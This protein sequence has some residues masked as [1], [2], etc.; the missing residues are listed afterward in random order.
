MGMKR[1][2]SRQK[3]LHRNIYHFLITKDQWF[4]FAMFVL[5]FSV[6]SDA[7]KS[8]FGNT[9]MVLIILSAVLAVLAVQTYLDRAFEIIPYGPK[10]QFIGLYSIEGNQKIELNVDNGL[11]P[12]DAE[13]GCL[14]GLIDRCFGDKGG[15]KRGICLIGRSGS[16]KSTIINQFEYSEDVPYKI[17]NF[18]ESYDYFEE[19]MMHLFKN[20]PEHN[21]TASSRTVMILDHFERYFSLAE[22]KKAEVKATIQ[23]IAR[24]PAVFIFSMRE[25]F[26]VSFL[27]EFDINNLAGINP[28]NTGCEGILFFKEYL[29]GSRLKTEENILICGSERGNDD[30]SVT[31]TMERLCKQAFG[32]KRGQEIYYHF[33]DGTLIQQQIIFNMMKHDFDTDGEVQVLDSNLDEDM[34]MKRY[35]DVQL[36]STGDYYMASRIMYLLCMG[37][38]SRIAFTDDDIRNA[39]CIF[40]KR[41]VEDF[42]KCLGKLHGLKL[43]KYSN[44]NS[45]MHY[46][47]AHD[48]IAKSFDAYANTELP[49]NVK[50][51][52]DEFKSEYTRHTAMNA[53]I[54]DYRKN[55][56]WKN[57][58]IFGR[59]V[60]GVSII[61]TAAVWGYDVKTGGGRLPWTVFALC[62]ASLLY[63][64]NFFM[65][66]TRHY[67]KGAWILVDFLYVLAM[68]FG[69]AA[70]VF[71]EYWLH[72][73]GAGNAS[74]GLSCLLIG[75]NSHLAESGRKWFMTY[76]LKTF[77]VGGLL[78]A[79]AFLV[80]FGS[81]ATVWIIETKSVLQFLPMAALL[82]YA[83]L[84]HLNKEFFYAGVEGI[85]STGK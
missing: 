16:G 80:Q 13:I 82:I 52:L 67:R 62:E 36:C 76:G 58:G 23:R 44:R 24:L 78:A 55:K 20:D 47:I 85:F 84:S 11:I 46:E 35:Y 29:S 27:T 19:Y 1:K 49:G 61:I 43:I 4:E 28:E 74:M 63:V 69:T 9:L 59:L 73:L 77:A 60:F 66:I 57:T 8:H 22:A 65:N 72:F 75:M 6:F 70:A 41:D 48:Y 17:E 39:L 42:K 25:E 5:G 54:S 21:L 79:L 45:T 71:S 38:N 18:S 33:K 64:F 26:F 34:M 83:Y 15:N 37:R 32:E 50:A 10:Q 53:A 3:G 68:C 40:E 2:I 7:L 56:K 51:A 30:K 12:R 14:K 81:F 31:R